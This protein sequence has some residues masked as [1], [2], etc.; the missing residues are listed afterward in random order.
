MKND[1]IIDAYN[2]IQPGDE[3]KNRVFDKVMQS[4]ETKR[5]VF[6]VAASFAAV[7]AVIC[8]LV[9]GGLF[10]PAQ[11]DNLFVIKA[12]AMEQQMD[13][14]IGLREVDLLG[15]THYWSIYNDG[16]VFYVSANLKCEGEN[17]RSV[18]FNTDEGFFA[19]QH[20]VIENGRIITEEGV[21]AGYRKAPGDIEYTLVMYGDDF[22]II[23]DSFTLGNDAITDDFLLFLGM[24]VSDRRE[25]PSQMT[26][27]AVATFNDGQTQE[28]T[29]TLD[30]ANA[31]N[32]IGVEILSPEETEIQQAEFERYQGILNRIPL[33][34]CEV[35]PGSVQTLTYGDTF[36]YSY[37]DYGQS[38]ALT[39][40]I[41]FFP[42][43]QESMDSAVTQGLF[44]ENGIFKVGSKL[45]GSQ[46]E[47]D[48]SDGFIAVIKDNGDG[49]YTGM[50]Y[51]VP[52]QM[53]LDNMK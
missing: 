31:E 5:P 4:Q 42:I 27:R 9:F 26:I 30:L 37:D 34:Q 8:L 32:L 36:E 52:G 18:D 50:V 25:Q 40:G 29:I 35:M 2:T 21:M 15:D 39:N 41:A 44:D 28:E 48:G 6:K 23:G 46:Y 20:L 14:S 3:V 51:I 10:S 47:Y 1:K 45:Y 7:A 43:T 13:G 16:S 12:Y 33:E 17:I 22:E 24:E 11:S 49:T 19:K 38:D 53:I